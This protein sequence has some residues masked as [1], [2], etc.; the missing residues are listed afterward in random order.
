MPLK[1][2]AKIYPEER[3]YFHTIIEPVLEQ[4]R[5]FVEFLGEVGGQAKDE[6]LG[7]AHAVLFPIRWPEPFGLVMIEALACGT[8]VV[9]YRNGSVPE[10]IEEGVTGYVVQDMEEAVQAVRR[11]GWLDRRICRQTF[12]QRFDAGR[13]ARD[14]LAVYRRLLY[15]GAGMAETGRSTPEPE[16]LAEWAWP[17]GRKPALSPTPFLGALPGAE[18][19]R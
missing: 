16:Q 3:N 13:M 15:D 1:I 9:G 5:S 2:D 4:S 18:Q 19:K 11:V 6:F 12:E 17:R 10:I 8:P 7:R 14:Y